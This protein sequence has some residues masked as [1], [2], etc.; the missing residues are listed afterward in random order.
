MFDELGKKSAAHPSSTPSPTG[1]SQL[2]PHTDFAPSYTQTFAEL[3]DLPAELIAMIADFMSPEYIRRFLHVSRRYRNAFLMPYLKVLGV[4]R[5]NQRAFNL[6][7]VLSFRVMRL[8]VAEPY[9]FAPRHLTLHL[10]HLRHFP[11]AIVQLLK[12]HKIESMELLYG[13]ST[14]D[15]FTSLHFRDVWHSLLGSNQSRLEH[16]QFQLKSGDDLQWEGPTDDSHSPQNG[17]NCNA[18]LCPLQLLD[19]P[20]SPFVDRSF[21]GELLSRITF[22]QLSHLWVSDIKT[23]EQ[24]DTLALHL[25]TSVVSLT[26]TMS[27]ETPPL[28]FVSRPSSKFRSFTYRDTP[29]GSNNAFRADRLHLPSTVVQMT[30]PMVFSNI[31]FEGSPHV[32]HIKLYR[33]IITQARECGATLALAST[34]NCLSSAG[35]EEA[36]LTVEVPSASNF[37]NANNVPFDPCSCWET[38]SA[39][40]EGYSHAWISELSFCVPRYYPTIFVSFSWLSFLQLLPHLAFH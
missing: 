26:L 23:Q 19:I 24:M 30:I 35:L 36:S 10:H 25:P 34:L 37:H 16:V 3:D 39:L 12:R 13:P 7:P 2:Q 6:V 4:M 8:I 11:S 5:Q 28:S 22:S 29:M 1:D 20:A 17:D 14:A 15:F 9:S 38:F 32:R 21:A 18:L 27:R 31:T 33:N 40:C